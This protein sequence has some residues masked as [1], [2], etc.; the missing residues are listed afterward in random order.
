MTFEG[1]EALIDSLWDEP[2]VLRDAMP[3]ATRVLVVD[4]KRTDDRAHEL[5]REVEELREAAWSSAGEGGRAPASGGL[6]DPATAMGEE[7]ARITPFRGDN[8]V[9]EASVWDVARGD[10]DKM[11]SAAKQLMRDGI[12]VIATAATTGQAERV[13]E[14]LRN[15]DIAIEFLDETPQPGQTAVAVASIEEGFW[16]P[17]LGLAVI[18]ESDL[19]GKRRA[20]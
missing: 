15:K 3:A 7:R 12:S 9:L 1:V 20:H 18:G 8:P 14:V 6:A 16:S 4:P 17:A 10:V 19:F 11:A 5:M 13:R 2:P